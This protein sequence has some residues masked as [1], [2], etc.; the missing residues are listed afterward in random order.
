M[1]R[2]RFLRHAQNA[3]NL[4]NELVAQQKHYISEAKFPKI[5]ALYVFYL[6]DRAVHVGRTRNLRQRMTGHRSNSHYSASFAFK[7]ARAATGIEPT[8]RKGEGR[9]A[10]ML[11]P[12]FKPAFDA[13]L[14]QVK[15]MKV[16]YLEVKD[17]LD[18]YMLELYA[19]LELNT[20]LSEF[21]TH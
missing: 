16:Q 19:A 20:S 15:G 7:L 3:A 21:D 11:D 12:V 1:G 4:Y 10:L 13:A 14:L 17:P 6:G 5:P 9:A 18:Q 2:L 8:Y